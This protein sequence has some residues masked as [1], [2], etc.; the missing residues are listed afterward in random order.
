MTSLHTH[1]KFYQDSFKMFV[2]LT[3]RMPC[4]LSQKH[5]FLGRSNNELYFKFQD[6]SHNKLLLIHLTGCFWINAQIWILRTI[7][8]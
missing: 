4:Q 8:L 7:K 2:V 6:A 5:N 3:D 1:T